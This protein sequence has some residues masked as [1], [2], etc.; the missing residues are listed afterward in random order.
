MK[1]IRPI[2]I[3]D[4]GSPAN[5]IS[6]TISENDYAQ[7]NAAT[8][9]TTGDKVIRTETHRIYERL[10][11]GTTS[12]PPE[13][14]SVNWLDIGPTNRWAMFDDV[15]GT[16][17]EASDEITVVLKPGRINS[18]AIFEVDASEVEV[19]LTLP[20]SPPEVIYNAVLDLVGGNTV[21]DWYEYF[22]EPLY[23]RTS[24]VILNL[25]DAALLDIPA[26]GD[27]EL[28]V[29][30]RKPGFTVK[31]GALIVGLSADLGET[32]YAPQISILDYSK[33]ETD[34]FG[35]VTVVKRRFS[36]RM[37]A[38]SFLLNAKVDDVTNI[39]SQFRSTP[40]VWI[41]ADAEYAALVV[42]G[43]YRDW[44]VSIDNPSTSILNIEVEGLI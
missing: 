5:F 33:K 7:W 28:T 18:L 4:T 26:Y 11:D 43:F 1:L 41:A 25:V 20:D 19:T 27:A 35:A 37:T 29:V 15:I 2:Y 21:G 3:S 16:S 39:L 32:I 6:S 9:Y 10:V 8:A 38:Q 24:A 12:T 14:D 42:Y 40:V 34:Q 31:V 22:Y 30:F 17:S 13:D 36:K 23:Q 44:N